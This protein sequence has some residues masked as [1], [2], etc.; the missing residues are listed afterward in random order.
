M[1]SELY[2]IFFN[3][4]NSFSPWQVNVMTA[5]KQPTLYPA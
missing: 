1:T 4:E 2:A 5:K 3:R